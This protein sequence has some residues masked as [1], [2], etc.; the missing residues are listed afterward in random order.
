MPIY[1]DMSQSELRRYILENREDIAAIEAFFARR[2][3][4]DQATWYS[5]PKTPEEW[6]QQIEAIQPVLD[7]D[8]QKV[9]PDS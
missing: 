9:Q 2:S 7:A 8:R 4:D 3:P 6:Q 1:D 5:P